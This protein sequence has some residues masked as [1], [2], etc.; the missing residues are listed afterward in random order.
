V[1]GMGLVTI[2]VSPLAELLWAA[3]AYS[4]SIRY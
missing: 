4:R 3:D 1:N 2:G